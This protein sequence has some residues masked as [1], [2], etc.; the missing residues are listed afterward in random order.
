MNGNSILRFKRQA[1]VFNGNIL[2]D[3]VRKLP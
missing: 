3:A 2:F 1:Q